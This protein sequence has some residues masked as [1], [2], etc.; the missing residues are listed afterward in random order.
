M[1]VKKITLSDVWKKHIKV[2]GYLAISAG[3]AYLLGLLAD[4]ESLLLLAPV[5]NYAIFAVKQ[6]LEKEG[7]VQAL[8]NK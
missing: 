2:V 8:R 6:E 5:I 3:L 1:T 4:N 7:V